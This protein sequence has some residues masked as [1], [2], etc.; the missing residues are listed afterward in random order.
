MRQKKLNILRFMN[1]EI[2]WVISNAWEN[3]GFFI[4]SREKPITKKNNSHGTA[5]DEYRKRIKKML[6]KILVF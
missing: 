4:Q 1:Y 6:E 3:I 2:K 5:F